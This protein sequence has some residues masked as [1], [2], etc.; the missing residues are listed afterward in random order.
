MT[1][2][3]TGRGVLMWLTAFFTLIFA[4]NAFFIVLSVKTFR[5]EDE[6]KPYLQGIEYN[7]T[8]AR[9]AEQVRLG[10][11]AQASAARLASGD[12]RI[13]VALRDRFGRPVASLPLVVELRH[14]SDENRDRQLTLRMPHTGQYEADAGKLSA[15]FW[16]LVVTS[17]GPQP[18]FE[19]TRRI[20]I[21]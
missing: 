5:G 20:W 18:S 6:Q 7:D 4:T 10:W 1:G 16:D 8:L 17:N 3:L 12:V 14:P 11:H 15:G 21:P 9:R 13:D 19:A 2:T